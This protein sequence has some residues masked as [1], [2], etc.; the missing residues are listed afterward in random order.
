MVL[1]VA[2]AVFVRLHGEGPRI[3]NGVVS[4]VHQRGAHVSV[5]DYDSPANVDEKHTYIHT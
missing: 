2:V 4:L 1:K 5:L 3:R